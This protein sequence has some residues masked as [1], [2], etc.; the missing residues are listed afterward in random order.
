LIDVNNGGDYKTTVNVLASEKSKCYMWLYCTGTDSP[1]DS[2][3]M[4]S[5]ALYDYH[6]SRASACAIEFLQGYS[7]YLQV[8]GYQGYASTQATLVGCWAHFRRQLTW[9]VATSS[10]SGFGKLQAHPFFRDRHAWKT[11]NPTAG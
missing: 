10:L 2:A 5:I 6:A 11:N 8:D 7:G 3:S 4:P 9:P 1:A